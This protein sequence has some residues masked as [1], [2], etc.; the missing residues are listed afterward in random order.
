MSETYPCPYC[1]HPK[2]WANG[3]HNGQKRLPRRICPK[4]GKSFTVGGPIIGHRPPIGE[5][6]MTGA[7]R[8]RRYRE[9]LKQKLAQQQQKDPQTT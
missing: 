5:R 4:C 8:Q 7:E 2:S 9:R 3:R 6:A 1:G